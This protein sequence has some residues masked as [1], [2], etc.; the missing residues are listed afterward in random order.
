MLRYYRYHYSYWFFLLYSS[1]I[2][3]S[4]L[5]FSALSGF[6]LSALR[7]FLLAL[8]QLSISCSSIRWR[9]GF[10]WFSSRNPITSSYLA[11][12]LSSCVIYNLSSIG[13][14]KAAHIVFISTIS[15]NSHLHQEISNSFQN[16]LS[17]PFLM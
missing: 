15:P 8:H 12:H 1:V 6:I 17:L 9:D 4:F 2:S 16:E 3:R 13:L 11:I 10:L 7:A 14:S 5:N